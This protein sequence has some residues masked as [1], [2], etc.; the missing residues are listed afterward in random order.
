VKHRQDVPNPHRFA[1]RID[2]KDSHPA[3][4]D[5]SQTNAEARGLGSSSIIIRMPAIRKLAVE[6]TAATPWRLSLPFQ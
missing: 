5:H 4:A 2:S 6:A 1:Y 3:A